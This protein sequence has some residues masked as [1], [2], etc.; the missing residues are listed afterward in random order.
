MEPKVE[1]T[2]QAEKVVQEKY[3]QHVSLEE[4]FAAKI[5]LHSNAVLVCVAALTMYI[6]L[7]WAF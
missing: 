3:E 4:N 7:A 6:A 5:V 2:E 1:E